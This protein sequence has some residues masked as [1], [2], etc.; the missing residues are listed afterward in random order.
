MNLEFQEVNR[1]TFQRFSKLGRWYVLAL[2][3]IATIAIAGQVLIQRHLHNQLGDSR[4]VNIAGTQRYRSQQLV[5]MV[6][7][8]Q[9]ETDSLRVAG[10]ASKLNTVLQQWSHGH[11][12][13]QHGDSAL[14][15]PE[16]N[17]QAVKSMFLE[18]EAS[19]RLIHNNVTRVIQEK[20]KSEPDSGA[21]EKSIDVILANEDKFL[22][23]MDA[24]V[25]RYDQE[26]RDKV[27]TLSKLEYALLAISIV[28]I[29][30][31]ILFVFRPTTIQVIKAIR[32]LMSA[33]ENARKLSKEIGA[34]YGSLEK[35]YERI[36]MV[37]LPAQNPRLY[38]KA[39]RGGNVTFVEDA[40]SEATGITEKT[41]AVL[42]DLFPGMAQPGDWMD[43]VVSI[44][45]E[46]GTW[47]GEVTF[48][49]VDGNDR[50]SD[51]II[52]PVY[53]EHQEVE[54]WVMMG[55]DNTQRK[56]AEKTMHQ[57][58][59]ATIE[60]QINQ[61]KFRSVLIL[62]GQE[63][64]RKRLAMDVHDGIGQMLTSLKFQ[65]ASIDLNDRARAAARIREAEQLIRDIIRE[66]RRVT[67]N[68]NPTVLGDFGLQ[69]AL[70]VFVQ[71]ISKLTD[72]RVHYTA[73]GE[74]DRLPQKTENNIFRIIQEAINNALKYSGAEQIEIKV[75]QQQNQLTI[76]VHDNGKGFD[77]KIVEQRHTNIES[78]RG[79]FNMYERT[80]YVNGK[81]TI[82]SSPGNGTTVTLAVP[83]HT[84]V[85]VE[86]AL[87]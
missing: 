20:R 64:E 43:E 80:E 82:A 16:A 86:D 22:Q 7:L 28:V 77:P 58:N 4:V 2:S 67:F 87:T 68:L 26:A 53:N 5:K 47:H 34:L 24:I 62:E 33:E 3:A 54:E 55:A 74:F 79:F 57:K 70:K 36:S 78:G 60:K 37:N 23:Q 42:S 65:I 39:D 81:L 1:A 48:K 51:I 30:L 32:Q 61:Q 75:E 18:L 85:A 66:A 56:Q 83:V 17:S 50:W 52:A 76:A 69:A 46:E 9:R 6:L 14:Q 12:A 73:E 45:S 29:L 11:Y 71:E 49:D 21:I 35:S 59:R 84:G 63:E 38:A 19:Y 40:F 72:I 10:Q 41:A 15:L 13:L 8:L 27:N 31:E 25:F 44:V